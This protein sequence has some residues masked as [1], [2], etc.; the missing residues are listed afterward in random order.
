MTSH[1]KYDF[2]GLNNVCSRLR[3][4][5]IFVLK[6]VSYLPEARKKYDFHDFTWP[7]SAVFLNPESADSFE[8]AKGSG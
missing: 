5:V 4:G 8:S 6:F 3:R 7:Y 2:L 1:G